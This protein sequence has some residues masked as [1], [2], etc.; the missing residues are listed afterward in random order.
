KIDRFKEKS[1]LPS[2]AREGFRSC[3][4]VRKRFERSRGHREL[5]GLRLFPFHP[6]SLKL[7]RGRLIASYQSL[8]FRA[9]LLRASWES[10]A[11]GRGRWRR[12]YSRCD[13]DSSPSINVVWGARHSALGGGNKDS[14]V[15]QGIATRLDLILQAWNSRP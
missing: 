6:P 4:L 2:P 10:D 7:R 14:G 5:S 15:I 9:R 12:S 13:I 11:H 8:A 1:S 3:P